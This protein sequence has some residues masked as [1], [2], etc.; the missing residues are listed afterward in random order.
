[1]NNGLKRLGAATTLAVTVGALASAAPAGASEQ[2]TQSA[3][4]VQCVPGWLAAWI[5][6]STGVHVQACRS[7]LQGGATQLAPS[8][9]AGEQPEDCVVDVSDEQT[10]TPSF[11]A[12][13]RSGPLHVI[14]V[15]T[16]AIDT[17]APAGSPAPATNR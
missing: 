15:A 12:W 10:G 9:A 2:H 4:R 1:V 8:T 16:Q 17:C 5:Y 11:V 7:G 6:A 13:L 3:Q 14:E